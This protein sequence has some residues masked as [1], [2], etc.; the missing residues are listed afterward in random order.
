MPPV[1]VEHTPW[2]SSAA[3]LSILDRITEEFHSCFGFL[4]PPPRYPLLWTHWQGGSSANWTETWL[5]QKTK[6]G[7]W[8]RI[9]DRSW[10]PLLK[11]SLTWWGN[12]FI[13]HTLTCVIFLKF[14]LMHDLIYDII[15]PVLAY[16]HITALG[17]LTNCVTRPATKLC[18]IVVIYTKP[19]LWDDLCRWSQFTKINKIHKQIIICCLLCISHSTMN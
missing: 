2:C 8:N 17:R 5:Y 16:E 4:P 13:S 10:S 14:Y 9:S 11:S 18:L 15:P 1:L 7:S 6:P 12:L 3:S 19:Q